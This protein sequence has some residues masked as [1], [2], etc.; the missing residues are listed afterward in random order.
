M[1]CY[2]YYLSAQPHDLGG[3]S[4]CFLF[5]LGDGVFCGSSSGDSMSKPRTLHVLSKHSV[6]QQNPHHQYFHVNE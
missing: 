2:I 5:L 6:T 4:E 3:S 1:Y